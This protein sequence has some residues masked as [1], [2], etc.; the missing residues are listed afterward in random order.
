MVAS[1]LH[2]QFG[3]SQG[4]SNCCR[5]VSDAGLHDIGWEL[6]PHSVI[7]F[8][9][10]VSTLQ[11]RMLDL[12]GLYIVQTLGFADIY[13]S[14]VNEAFIMA[15]KSSKCSIVDVKLFVCSQKCTHYALLQ[16]VRLR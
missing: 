3:R 8:C 12:T 14:Y 15:R 7:G 5:S 16:Q 4:S 2:R 10:L 6:P 11:K 1:E 13:L 9:R